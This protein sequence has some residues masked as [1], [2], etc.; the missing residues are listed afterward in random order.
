MSFILGRACAGRASQGLPSV[1][2]VER[3]QLGTSG[4]LAGPDQAQQ[5]LQAQAALGR[6]QGEDPR[7]ARWPQA[8][9]PRRRAQEVRCVTKTQVS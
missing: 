3:E 8:Q 7:S 1:P 5:P 9:A 4:A 6:A 2:A